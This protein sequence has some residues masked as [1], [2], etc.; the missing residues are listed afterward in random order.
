MLFDDECPHYFLVGQPRDQIIIVDLKHPLKRFCPLIDYHR[1]AA[2]QEKPSAALFLGSSL[3]MSRHYPMGQ[4][5]TS[6]LMGIH[7]ST[8]VFMEHLRMR[9]PVPSYPPVDRLD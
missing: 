1:K 4:I 7:V 2:L 5:P 6:T 8:A 3:Y 9:G